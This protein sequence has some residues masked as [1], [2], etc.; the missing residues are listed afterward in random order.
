MP[1]P[2][3]ITDHAAQGIALLTAAF[4]EQ[5][6]VVALAKAFLNR[7]QELEN[8]IFDFLF[9]I[10]LANHPLAGGPWQ[11]LDQLGALIGAPTRN[12]L[13]DAQYA[14]VLKIVAKVDRSNGR[15]ED[16]IQLVS[17]VLAGAVYQEFYPGSW[18]VTV[19]GATDAQILALEQYLP[20]AKMAGTQGGVRYSDWSAPTGVLIPD[21]Q[22]GMVPGATG[23]AYP[24]SSLFMNALVAAVQ[25]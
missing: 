12:G 9:K 2:I 3:Q 7:V 11:I 15:A 16:I 8:A 22:A 5:P 6:T 18:G 13:T 24:P 17:L 4:R 21:W 20:R 19:L 10:Q 23:F 25:V 1:V 14:A